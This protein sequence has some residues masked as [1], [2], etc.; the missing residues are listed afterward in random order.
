MTQL[1]AEDRAS[2]WSALPVLMAGTYLIVLDFFIVDVAIP[3]MQRDLHAS[4][5]AIEWVVAGYG[6]TFAVSLITAGRLG[7]RVGRR[8][9]FSA[10]IA[11]FVSASA[12]CG[13]AGNV[14]VLDV[15][16]LAQ[17][18]A[19][20]LISANVLSSIGVLYSGSARIRAI[21]VYG[22]V[23]GAAAT[24][25]QLLG[26][27][28]IETDAFGLGW[29]SVF[30]IN[31]PIGVAALLLAPRLVPESR[32]P[33][34]QRLDPCAVT[35]LT[36][37]LAAV[38]FPLVQGRQLGWPPWTWISLA[39]SPVVFAGL[40]VY[41]QRRALRGGAPLL[42]PAVLKLRSFCPGLA[43]QLMFWCGQASFFLFLALYLQ[44]G[45]GLDPL[46]SGLVFTILAAA[47]FAASLRAP[48]LT[49]R[50]GRDLIALA[51]LTVV[52]GDALLMG[53]VQ[54][55]GSGGSIGLLAPGLL[56]VGAGQGLGI[57]PLT[58]T[59]LAHVDA[60]RAGTVSGLLTTMQ[61]VG[62]TLGV[63]ITGVIFFGQVRHGYALAFTLSLLELS[64]T[65]IVVAVLT[66]LL[67]KATRSG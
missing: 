7:D 49:R 20:A 57:T 28:L 46:Q 22:M 31:I 50:Y 15:A 5:S 64:C 18:C 60:R 14:T 59:V 63:A 47:F 38:A 34:A 16:R 23:L 52:A 48:A 61:Q 62:N 44:D 51:A 9:A 13:T 66:R 58:S 56:L 33:D 41:Q 25:G 55:A 45:R 35:L 30:L 2:P 54:G 12:I 6:L 1:V 37:G 53:A 32:A 17:G 43:T 29:R 27:V 3:S 10:G 4:A 24:T 21:T 26:G 39:S 8:R 36:V 11:L 42:D 19:A 40:A 67:P 65:L